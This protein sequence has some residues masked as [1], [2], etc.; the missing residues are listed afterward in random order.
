MERDY[1]EY[2]HKNNLYVIIVIIKLMFIRS[3]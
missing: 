3:F 2:E 1:I